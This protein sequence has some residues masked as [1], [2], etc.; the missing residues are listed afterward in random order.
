MPFS[1]ENVNIMKAKYDGMTEQDLNSMADE[2]KK[3]QESLA[4][5]ALKHQKK[6]HYYP[7]LVNFLRNSE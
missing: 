7:L 1:A 4:Q 6:I 5:Y 2:Y 3:K